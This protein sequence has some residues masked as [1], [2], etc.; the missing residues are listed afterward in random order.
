MISLILPKLIRSVARDGIFW[1]SVGRQPAGPCFGFNDSRQAPRV[2]GELAQFQ[3]VNGSD[4]VSIT[5]NGTDARSKAPGRRHP[6]VPAVRSLQF[7]FGAGFFE[8]LLGG[9]C[10]RL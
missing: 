8:L 4:T 3:I 2:P 6:A 5:R 7:H 10:I 9:F 1:I